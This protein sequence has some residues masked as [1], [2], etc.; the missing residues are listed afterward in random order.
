MSLSIAEKL[1]D[2]N[3]TDQSAE[4]ARR[5]ACA[6]RMCSALGYRFNSSSFLRAWSLVQVNMH[7]RW[8]AMLQ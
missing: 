5:C 4:L 2:G 7:W 3:G 8:T 6:D 1:Q